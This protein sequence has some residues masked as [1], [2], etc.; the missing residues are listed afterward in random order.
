M[1]R[2]LTLV[3]VTAA[4]L[5]GVAPRATAQ[6]ELPP[7]L[8]EARSA[9]RHVM[10]RRLPGWEH[11]IITPIQ[12]SKRIIT[13]QWERDGRGV[14]ISVVQFDSPERAEKVFKDSRADLEREE[15]AARAH[16]RPEFKLILEELPDVGDAGFI[17][18]AVTSVAAAF[19]KGNLT[20]HISVYAPGSKDEKTLSR[21]LAYLVARAIPKR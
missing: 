5:L 10:S 3:C 4:L 14:R 7:Q 19:R 8:A 2:Q 18:N 12:G 9:L 6:E 1:R 20:V 13:D 16:G 17:K 11:K 21:E 15:R